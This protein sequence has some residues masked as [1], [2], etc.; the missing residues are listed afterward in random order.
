MD[1]SA[2]SRASG[3]PAD[4]PPARPALG[5]GAVGAAASRSR[6]PCGRRGDRGGPGRDRG[7]GDAGAGERLVE[8]AQ[9][10]AVRARQASLREVINATGV[11]VHTNL[12]R[13]PPQAALQALHAAATGYSNLEFDL[14]AGRRGSRQAHV[15]GLWQS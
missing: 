3:P 2:G 11:I 13:A 15:D 5:G 6:P 4:L 7:G 9:E 10:L 12:G 1:A 14:H 8:R